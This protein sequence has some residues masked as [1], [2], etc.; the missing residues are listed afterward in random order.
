[1]NTNEL[2]SVIIPA[3]D[4][5]VE[6]Q[7]T[8]RS[9]LKQSH[10]NIE[11]FIIENNSTDLSSI[12]DVVNG[13]EDTRLV[14]VSLKKCQNANVARN[15]GAKISN[16]AYIAFLDSDDIWSDSHISDC[17]RTIHTLGVGFVYGGAK[18]FNGNTYK[19]REARVLHKNE[20]AVDYIL[21]FNGGFA[22]TSS[23]FMKRESF[24]IVSWDESLKR[25][26]D[27]DFFIR[28]CEA[29]SSGVSSSQTVTINWLK[30]EKRAYDFE[31]MAAFYSKYS[32]I[33]KISTSL[34]YCL[35][36]FKVSI[37]N[38]EA[39]YAFSFVF[40]FLR[41]IILGK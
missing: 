33:M 35:I 2:V 8:L 19:F 10:Q 6:L 39:R 25:N 30:G 24:S 9:V 18:I 37:L 13:F 11:V 14:L 3:R 29:V 31:S 1:M 4:R 5:V 36:G 34:R 22:Q 12:K 15:H 20:S 40:Y 16:G 41:K 21:G 26:Q 17:L 32:K 27:L 38:N 28:M 7:A 23:Y